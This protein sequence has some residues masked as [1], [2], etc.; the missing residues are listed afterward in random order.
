[1][2]LLVL[3]SFGSGKSSL[4]TE[5]AHELLLKEKSIV[6]LL[7][8]LRDLRGASPAR[9]LAEELAEHLRRQWKIDIK[10]APP[11]GTCY[12]LLCDGFDELELYFR[13]IESERWVSE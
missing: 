7:V 1:Y 11:P 12:C 8:P 3:G 5:F 13:A 9:P 2:P 6:P 4:L 10:S